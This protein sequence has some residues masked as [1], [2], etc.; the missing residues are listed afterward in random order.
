MVANIQIQKT[1]A[2]ITVVAK[3]S[4]RFCLERQAFGVLL[5]AC[6]VAAALRPGLHR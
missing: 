6:V 2:Q 3:G 5:D 1:G 4:P